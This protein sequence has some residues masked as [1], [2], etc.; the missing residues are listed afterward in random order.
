MQWKGE[1]TS[2]LGPFVAAGCA[3]SWLNN[4]TGR[5]ASVNRSYWGL[6]SD[7]L[8]IFPVLT[9]P[10]HVYATITSAWDQLWW[11]ARCVAAGVP[12]SWVVVTG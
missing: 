8:D 7:W 11:G 4:D 12:W 3:G 9:G 5:S 2:S 6:T 10:G 1:V